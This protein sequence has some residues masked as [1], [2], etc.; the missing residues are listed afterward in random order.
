MF[1]NPNKIRAKILELDDYC[2]TTDQLTHLEEYL[3]TP[4][5]MTLLKGYRGDT[6]L[7]GRAEQYML[8]MMRTE[9][10][11]S[12]QAQESPAPASSFSP[13]KSIAKRIQCMLFKQQF[14]PRVAKLRTMVHDIEKACDDVKL[15]SRFKK[16]LKTILKIGNQLNDQE[17]VERQAGFT[18][19]SL[20]KLQSAKAFDKTTSILQYVVTLIH[21]SDMNCLY[22]TEVREK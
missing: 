3:P 11:G 17:G 7:L 14:A 20:L 12:D 4:E 1:V 2:F 10:N 13:T 9:G 15:S 5:E 19:D 21:R 8:V 18:V 6:E 16:V 22:F